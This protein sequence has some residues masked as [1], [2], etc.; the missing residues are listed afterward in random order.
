MTFIVNWSIDSAIRDEANARFK[1]TGAPP[2]EGVKTVGRWHNLDGSGGVAIVE[3][4][5]PVVLGKFI[6]EW[7]DLLEFQITPAGDDSVVAQIIA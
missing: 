2:P 1:A 4:N 3:S 5:D 6:Q 7:S